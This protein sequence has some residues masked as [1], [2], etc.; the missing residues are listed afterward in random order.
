MVGTGSLNDFDY[1]DDGDLLAE[2]ISLLQ[3]TLLIL[4]Q[5]AAP[6]G[7]QVNWAKT[8]IQSLSDFLP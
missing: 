4:S 5:E 3:S 2:L 6:L 1:A 8:K 7:L